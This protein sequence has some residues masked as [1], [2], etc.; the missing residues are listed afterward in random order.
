M[1][2]INSQIIENYQNAIKNRKIA[3]STITLTIILIV[4]AYLYLIWKTVTDFR[5][6]QLPEFS[7][8]LS[9]E[10]ADFMPIVVDKVKVMTD[11][12][13]PVYVSSFAKTYARDEEKYSQILVEEFDALEKKSTESWEKMEEAIAQM[14]LDQEIAASE[15]LES[16]IGSRN[17]SLIS[18]SYRQALQNK[19]EK[20][21]SEHFEGHIKSSEQLFKKLQLIAESEPDL[22]PNDS[23]YFFGMLMEL[24]GLQM[25]NYENDAENILE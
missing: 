23:Q 15:A 18:E 4:V 9:A 3:K 5:E 6:Y 24:L 7:A 8:T 12:L 25:Q 22:Q 14:T 20:T 11:R 21:F 19:L 17:I 16:I 2:Q 1:S 10:A 13:I